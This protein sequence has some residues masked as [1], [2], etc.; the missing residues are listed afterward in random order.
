MT[1]PKLP[2]TFYSGLMLS[3]CVTTSD[4]PAAAPRNP[5]RSRGTRINPARPGLSAGRRRTEKR[6]APLSEALKIDPRSSSAKSRR[7]RWC[8]A[9]VAEY[10]RRRSSIFRARRQ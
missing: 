6:Q 4:Q 3:A 5:N 1:R 7:W 2:V 9:R 8:F 10:T